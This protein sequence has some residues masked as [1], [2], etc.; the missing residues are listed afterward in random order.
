ML[1][2]RCE[3]SIFFIYSRLRGDKIITIEWHSQCFLE[4][5]TSLGPCLALLWLWLCIWPKI[6][7]VLFVQNKNEE[8]I[9]YVQSSWR[10]HKH[11]W[12]WFI[13]MKIG[14]SREIDDASHFIMLHHTNIG[15]RI[16]SP[17]T[18]PYVEISSL[19]ALRQ[20]LIAST[21]A[22]NIKP[23]KQNYQIIFYGKCCIHIHTHD[24]TTLFGISVW[25]VIP[26][27]LKW[28]GVG[29]KDRKPEEKNMCYC[30][31]LLLLPYKNHSSLLFFYCKQT[32]YGLFADFLFYS[33]DVNV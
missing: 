15:I 21:W 7:I 12:K 1:C 32:L 27:A 31:F 13:C 19:L 30:F 5:Q 26:F 23:N 28:S 29:E 8:S 25:N 9:C 6:Y 20:K 22:K 33:T 3:F 24:M 16:F 18:I 17:A 14:W 4:E 11:T 10:T 2:I